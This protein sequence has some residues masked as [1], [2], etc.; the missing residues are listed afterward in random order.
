MVTAGLLYTAYEYP[1][2]A[3]GIALMLLG[4]VTVLL[5][6]ARRVLRKLFTRRAP[7]TATAGQAPIDTTL[8]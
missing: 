2:I 1:A 6:A 7:D 5:L 4:L 8:P 3:G